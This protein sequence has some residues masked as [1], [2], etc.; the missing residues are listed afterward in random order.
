MNTFYIYVHGGK[1]DVLNLKFDSFF[2]RK[3]Q[4]TLTTTY[5]TSIEN[6]FHLNSNRRIINK[7][8]GAN[9]SI[10]VKFSLNGGRFSKL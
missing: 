9:V 10:M 2:E 7:K 3:C 4:V 5:W 1:E 8:T 6:F